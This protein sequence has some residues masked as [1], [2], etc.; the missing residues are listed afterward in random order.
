MFTIIEKSGVTFDINNDDTY[1]IINSFTE[2][3]NTDIIRYN[4]YKDVSE[5]DLPEINDAQ[6]IAYNETIKTI[7][8]NL[9][10]IKLKMINT[11]SRP[12]NLNDIFF[13]KMRV[14]N[15]GTPTSSTTSSPA[16]NIH[17][18]S[19]NM[20]I[21]GT[22][23]TN[24]HYC[25]I[26]AIYYL[27]I[28]NAL[29]QNYSSSA[30]WFY[31]PEIPSPLSMNTNDY[32]M[33][34]SQASN[35]RDLGNAFFNCYKRIAYSVPVKSNSYAIWYN[36][37]LKYKNFNKEN[38]PNNNSFYTK[39]KGPQIMPEPTRI[40]T[41]DSKNYFMHLSPITISDNENK[42]LQGNRAFMNP[43]LSNVNIFS[44]MRYIFYYREDK[45]QNR[46]N[47][48]RNNSLFSLCYIVLF[49]LNFD[50]LNVGNIKFNS[51]CQECSVLI[52]AIIKK[53]SNINID[54]IKVIDMELKDVRI[55]TDVSTCEQLVMSYINEQISEKT[56]TIRDRAIIYQDKIRVIYEE[57]FL[58]TNRDKRPFEDLYVYLQKI[59]CVLYKDE[60]EFH[61]DHLDHKVVFQPAYL[62]HEVE[63]DKQIWEKKYLK[64]KQKYL[65]LRKKINNNQ[66]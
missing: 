37:P 21:E 23:Y 48:V 14:D 31:G 4:N 27:N 54:D 5:N 56:E 13:F 66:L 1:E 46:Q 62:A 59:F 15:L 33:N 63:K 55:M 11:I 39:L 57:Y 12:V 20:S 49:Y 19:C 24:S 18:D 58:N 40:G 7:I 25:E 35:N 44:T 6:L 34:P 64:Y 60:G 43:R 30:L 38:Y 10:K 26:A 47:L 8:E 28:K 29:T 32:Q 17:L 51:I 50:A 52:K 3:L 53:I 45:D 2:F 41:E 9:I 36:K 42:Y 22:E 61:P 16:T 65:D